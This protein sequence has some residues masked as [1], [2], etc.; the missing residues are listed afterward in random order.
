[1]L[2]P[3]GEV[4]LP[5]VVGVAASCAT[6]L[7]Q[8]LAGREHITLGSEVAENCPPGAEPSCACSAASTARHLHSGGP[9]LSEGYS[10]AF[11]ANYRLESVTREALLK[12]CSH[13]HAHACSMEAP[14]LV[15]PS[16]FCASERQLALATRLPR[17]PLPAILFTVPCTVLCHCWFM[18]PLVS[19]Y[20][21]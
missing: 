5:W 18:H 16:S 10:R 11:H 13:A 6:D 4:S 8:R 21:V 19:L 3:K 12:A 15:E 7:T 1:M 9:R 14:I 2:A 17:R 20:W